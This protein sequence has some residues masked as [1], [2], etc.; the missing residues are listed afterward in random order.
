VLTSKREGFYGGP[1]CPHCTEG[2]YC[3]LCWAA[4]KYADCCN[5]AECLDGPH[6]AWLPIQVTQKTQG[7]VV[8]TY[9][10]ESGH[11]WTCGWSPEYRAHAGLAR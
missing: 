7:W 4:I 3:T 8:A 10:C 6:I 2:A 9:R 11:I 5:Q 1:G